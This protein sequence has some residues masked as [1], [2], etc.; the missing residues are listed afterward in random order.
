MA[1]NIYDKLQQYIK[2]SEN[3]LKQIIKNLKQM[4]SFPFALY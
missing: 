3:K 1:E 4:L 2:L